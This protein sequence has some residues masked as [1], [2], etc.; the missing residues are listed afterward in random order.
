MEP[1]SLSDEIWNEAKNARM[2][3]EVEWDARVRQGTELC[4]EEKAFL[5]RRRSFTKKALARYLEIPETDIH[6]EDVPVITITGSGG[7]LRAMVAGAGYYQALTNTGLY[8]CATYTAGVSGSCWLQ[9]LYLSSI[10]S[11]S[12]NRVIEHLKQRI[13]VHIAYPPKALELLTSAPVNKYLLRGVVERLRTGY[14]SF[15][16]V[17]L[18]GILLGARLLVPQNELD[19]S[20]EDLKLSNQRRFIENGEQ[21]LPIYTAVRHE[22]PFVGGENEKGEII[23]EETKELASKA[24][25]SWFQWFEATPYELFCEDLEGMYILQKPPIDSS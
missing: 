6:D 23:T 19:V 17:D 7:G 10:G 12:F 20:D 2:N 9:S 24:G 18:Y 5:G 15:G 3:P 16:L 1:G 21:P 4:D 13:C 11:C 14:S 8:D 22:I 25:E